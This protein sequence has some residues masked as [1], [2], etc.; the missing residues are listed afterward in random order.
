[1]FMKVGPGKRLRIYVSESATWGGAPLYEA[2]VRRAHEEGLAGATVTQGL[3]GFGHS[4]VI[5]TSKILRLAEELPMIVEIVDCSDRID[6]FLEH[7]D[8]MLDHGLVTTEDL[9]VRSYGG[10]SQDRS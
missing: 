9:Q 7:V 3:L 4:S 10:K 8:R 2:L 5:H 1:M 6:A